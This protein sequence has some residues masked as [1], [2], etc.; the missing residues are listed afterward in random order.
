MSIHP[1]AIIDPSAHIDASGF[2]PLD[3][4]RN[5]TSNGAKALGLTTTGVVRAGYDADLLI[6]DSNPMHSFK[7]LYGTGIDVAEEGKLVHKGGVRWTIK[8]GI[9]FD[10]ESLRADIREVVRRAKEGR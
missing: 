8:K 10:A 3:V 7:V 2:H 5:A 6:V 9:V 4:I 1:S